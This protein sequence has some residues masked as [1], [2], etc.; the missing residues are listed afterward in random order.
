MCWAARGPAAPPALRVEGGQASTEQRAMAQQ[1]F[2]RYVSHA[3]LSQVP[4]PTQLG[5]LADGTPYRIVSVA[6]Q[7]IMQ[8]WPAQSSRRVKVDSGILFS[9]MQSGEIW[10][11]VNE[12]VD[13]RLSA[14]WVFRN[15]AQEYSAPEKSDIFALQGMTDRVIA[16]PG[17]WGYSYATQGLGRYGYLNVFTP[18]STGDYHGR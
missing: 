10:L 9:Q 13:G 6:G 11:L 8:I 12:L 5:K 2:A 18:L 4:N 7:H 3:R 16:V 1:V 14:N 15:I 17:G